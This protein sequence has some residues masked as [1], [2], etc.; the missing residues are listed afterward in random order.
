[1]SFRD[2]MRKK[3]DNEAAAA[4]KARQAEEDKARREAQ[5]QAAADKPYID[6]AIKDIEDHHKLIDKKQLEHDQLMAKAAD[7]KAEYLA[8]VTEIGEIYRHCKKDQSAARKYLKDKGHETPG[9]KTLHCPFE[10]EL[11]DSNRAWIHANQIK[12]AFRGDL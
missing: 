9:Y 12:K 8:T 6:A 1:M 3:R 11:Q 10:N 4:A 2:M 5:A 7:L